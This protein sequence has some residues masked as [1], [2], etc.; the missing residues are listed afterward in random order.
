MYTAT[1]SVSLIKIPKD[2]LIQQMTEND[3]RVSIRRGNQMKLFIFSN[4]LIKKKIID[5]FCHQ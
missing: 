1:S 5:L 3:L 2:V 4:T